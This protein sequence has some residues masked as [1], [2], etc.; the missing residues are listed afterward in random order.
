MSTGLLIR[1]LLQLSGEK[2][3]SQAR[4]AVKDGLTERA[5]GTEATVSGSVWKL[6]NTETEQPS[7]QFRILTKG[8]QESG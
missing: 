5:L 4:A 2:E 8:V 1:S 3:Q 7:R 6:E